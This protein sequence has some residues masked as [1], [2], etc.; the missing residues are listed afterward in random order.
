MCDTYKTQTRKNQLSLLCCCKDGVELVFEGLALTQGPVGLFLM[1]ED[2]VI[3]HRLGN[4]QRGNHLP[5][6]FAALGRQAHRL[7][8]SKEMTMVVS[9][10]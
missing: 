1:T 9:R 8:V 4:A 10:K 6:K 5:V 2:D 3:Q 7:T